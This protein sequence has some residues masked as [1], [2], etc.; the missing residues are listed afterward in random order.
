PDNK[1]SFGGERRQRPVQGR[2]YRR[3]RNLDPGNVLDRDHRVAVRVREGVNGT[4]SALR[5]SSRLRVVRD[6]IHK[7]VVSHVTLLSGCIRTWPTATTS[8]RA[9]AANYGSACPPRTR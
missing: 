9:S 3:P 7:R 4:G 8:Q 2:R 5:Q 1:I 6:Q